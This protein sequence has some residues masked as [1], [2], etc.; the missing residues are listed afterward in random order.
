MI[1]VSFVVVLLLSNI[2]AV[3]PVR[4]FNFL[5]MDL[6]GGTLLFPV[7]YIF[8]DVLV[9]VYGYARS[10]RVIWM[11]FGFNLLAALLFWIIVKLPPSPEWQMQ[12]AFAMIL[13]QTPRIV[14]GSL[15]AFWCGEFVN[16]YVMA[17]M[18]VWTGGQFLWTRTIGSTIVGQAVDTA[19]FQIIAFAGVWDGGLLLRVMLWNY[20]AKVLYETLA[21]PITYAVVHFLKRAEQEDYYDYDT[22]FNPFALRA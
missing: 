15:I 20:T 1:T 16:S 17:K 10:R 8:G 13:G 22:N 21:T 5:G 2:V 7:S 9:E 11:G 6:D 14:A 3:K 4:L 19:L 12:D 18:K